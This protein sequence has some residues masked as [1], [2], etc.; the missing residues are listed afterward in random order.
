MQAHQL[1]PSTR[2]KMNEI[3]KCGEVEGVGG[4]RIYVALFLDSIYR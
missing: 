2:G 3:H 1:Y 4:K